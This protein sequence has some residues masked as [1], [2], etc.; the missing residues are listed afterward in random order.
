MFHQHAFDFEGPD[1][2]ARGLNH[3]IAAADEPEPA[4]RVAAHEVAAEVPAVGKAPAVAEIVAEIA[5]KHRW[6]AGAQRQ[7][8]LLAD[9]DRGDG[10][11]GESAH[12]GR[13]DPRQRPAHRARAHI[14]FGW[15]GNHDRAGLGLP[16][17]VVD[18]PA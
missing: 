9:A 1:A 6:P 5:A 11:A 10:A 12:R 2:M 3:V 13:L 16:P 4:P 18:G 7:L 17:G 8:A 15:V 14:L